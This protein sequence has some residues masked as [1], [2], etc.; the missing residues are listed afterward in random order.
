MPPPRGWW[1]LSFCPGITQWDLY[2][3]DVLNAIQGFKDHRTTRVVLDEALGLKLSIFG[4]L[5]KMSAGV[6]D[7][8]ELVQRLANNL[9]FR[10]TD[11]VKVEIGTMVRRSTT[12]TEEDLKAVAL[13]TKPHTNP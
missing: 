11:Y 7:E 2:T 1:I 8:H 5:L 12:S 10:Q 6:S 3:R 9:C 13:R 4:R